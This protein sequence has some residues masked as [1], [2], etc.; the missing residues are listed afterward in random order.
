[1]VVRREGHQ[2]FVDETTL[3]GKPFASRTEITFRVIEDGTGLLHA[4]NFQGLGSPRRVGHTFRDDNGNIAVF[5]SDLWPSDK[6]NKAILSM[7]FY[8]KGTDE[9][10]I[11]AGPCKV[12]RIEQAPL[13]HDPKKGTQ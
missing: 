4:M 9:P 13:D 1:M 3:P 5:N 2:G 11:F 10:K 7:Y 6:T 8:A 12:T